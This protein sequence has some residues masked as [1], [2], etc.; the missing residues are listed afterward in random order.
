MK[1]IVPSAK[2][3]ASELQSIGK[4]PPI[5]YPINQNISFDFFKLKYDNLAAEMDIIC[6]EGVDKVR[7]RLA[8]YKLS[9][10]LNLIT[11]ERL[12]DLGYS[13]L[14]GLTDKD[15]EVIIHFADTIIMDSL[16]FD[17]Q[18]FFCYSQEYINDTW[19]F[20]DMHDGQI[21]AV[22][23]KVAPKPPFIGD[24]GKCNFFIGV[25]KFS[26][27][28]Y[29]KKCL[30]N[31]LAKRSADTDSFYSAL[32][33]YSKTRQFSAY[34]VKEWFDIGHAQLYFKTRMHVESRTFN[35]IDI[36]QDRGILKKTSTDTEKF[37]GEIKWYLKLPTDLEYVSPRIFDY[38]LH[39]N[40]PYVCMEYYSYRTLHELFLYGDL[41]AEQ[42]GKIF[43]K[44]K[45]VLEDFSRYKLHD[46]HLTDSLRAMYLEK[47]LSRLNRLK[48][49]AE[50]QSLF[51][52]PICIN[53]YSYPPLDEVT[54]ILA[55]IVP[56][57]LC[58]VENFS[59]IHGDFCFPNVM[60]D[61]NLDFI[62]LIDPR[63]KFGRYDIYGD[64]RYEFAKLLHSIEGKYDYIIKDL[65]D[66][67]LQG[68]NHFRFKILESARAFD[69]TEIFIRVFNDD[70]KDRLG[71]IRLIESLLFL[72]MVPLHKEN[73]NRQYAMLCTA[74]K[75]LHRL[76]TM[77]A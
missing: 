43:K 59:I 6:F 72:S 37:I 11:L 70:L 69:L 1:V 12:E 36:D 14:Q 26:D 48:S 75:I 9:A 4:I 61:T 13:I 28:A 45:F 49:Q 3:I 7:E 15:N 34:A 29:F 63:G 2:L 22:N 50:F 42:W 31:V 73:I 65:F 23:D 46:E 58:N 71:E 64:P 62:K 57:L 41:T 74:M 16:P 27:G 56:R 10:K 76:L 39:Y 60:I 66:L 32:M 47:T 53:G 21:T 40:R 30:E 44:I 52:R 55:E 54:Q 38:A 19:T 18:D 35:H 25:F 5:I 33:R 17:A 51:N 77:G 8:T 20:Y 24:A 68:E 67:E